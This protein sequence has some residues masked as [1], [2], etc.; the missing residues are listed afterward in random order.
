[1]F[2]HPHHHKDELQLILSYCNT[3]TLN[4]IAATNSYLHHVCRSNFVFFNMHKHDAQVVQQNSFTMQQKHSS[5]CTYLFD[6]YI[7]RKQRHYLRGQ[8]QKQLTATN[9]G[10]GMI[11]AGLLLCGLILTVMSVLWSF[12]SWAVDLY[13]YKP[14]LMHPLDTL[15]AQCCCYWLWFQ[16]LHSLVYLFARD[17]CHL[18]VIGYLASIIS[19]EANIHSF[20]IICLTRRMGCAI[21]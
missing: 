11:I 16:L 8:L 6:Y 19:T 9:Y 12:S 14:I 4:S 13:A 21:M 18:C 5:N 2:S 15:E 7:A 20:G 17:I 3:S 10:Y 1:M